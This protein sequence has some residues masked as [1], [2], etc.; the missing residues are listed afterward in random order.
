MNSRELSRFDAFKGS[1]SYG[2]NNVNDFK[3][4]TGTVKTKA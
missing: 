1:S 4:L 3:P 2:S